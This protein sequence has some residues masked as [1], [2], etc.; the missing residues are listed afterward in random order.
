MTDHH[1]TPLRADTHP[2]TPLPRW[3]ALPPYRRH[4]LAGGVLLGL[5]VWTIR[6]ALYEQGASGVWLPI[7][8]WLVVSIPA[9][10]DHCDRAHGDLRPPRSDKWR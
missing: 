4:V 9:A 2:P 6:A 3:R 1:T 10:L 8:F 7:A 5:L